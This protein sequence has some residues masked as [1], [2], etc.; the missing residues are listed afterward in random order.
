MEGRGVMIG[1]ILLLTGH[2][3]GA[4]SCEWTEFPDPSWVRTIHAVR[5]GTQQAEVKQEVQQE[6]STQI[7]ALRTICLGRG[8]EAYWYR[9]KAVQCYVLKEQVACAMDGETE[10]EAKD[11]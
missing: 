8:G 4:T 3:L 11:F 1:A 9:P 5:V 10:C 2:V 6:I 7:E